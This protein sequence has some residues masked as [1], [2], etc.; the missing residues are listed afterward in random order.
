M[1]ETIGCFSNNECVALSHHQQI[2]HNKQ[3][4]LN[5]SKE[6]SLAEAVPLTRLLSSYSAEWKELHLEFHRSPPFEVPEITCQQHIL[7]IPTVNGM[8]VERKTAGKMHHL[9]FH[10]GDFCLSPQNLTLQT[11]WQDELEAIQ[12]IIEPDL[13]AQV[14]HELIDPDQVELPCHVKV[15][16]PLVYQLGFALKQSLETWGNDSKLY[17]DSATT[18]LAVHLLKHYTIRKLK[19]P[20]HEGG[21]SPSQLKLVEDYVQNCLEKEICLDEIAY[22]LDLS[23]YYFCHLFKQ[24]TGLSPY[25][26]VIQCRI[27]R[28][29]Q[30]LKQSGWSIGEVALA[31][32]FSHQSHLHRHFKRLTGITPKKF[33]NL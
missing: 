19:Q 17:A 11:R 21:L 24:S 28:A 33:S 13:L 23:R 10:P 14:A 12:L 29:K 4:S 5:L 8:E 2:M 7:T 30:L 20:G 31:C 25:Q 15:N 32:G 27:E 1:I 3:P 6:N 22:L 9:I 18:F 26:Y 16:D